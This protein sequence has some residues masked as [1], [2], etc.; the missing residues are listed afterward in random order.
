VNDFAVAT[1]KPFTRYFAQEDLTQLAHRQFYTGYGGGY[2]LFPNADAEKTVSVDY[3]WV[4]GVTG[5]LHTELG[6]LHRLQPP[7]T[8]FAPTAGCTGAGAF[9]PGGR[10]W[11]RLTH[12]DA[13]V[14]KGGSTDANA[15]T[16][17]QPGSILIRG[18]RG[19]SLH[20]HVVWREAN[21]WR[22]RERSTILTREQS[23]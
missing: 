3:T 16:E 12:S 11:V 19:A 8:A 13:D 21:R 1:L 10:W 14:C 4:N 23:R 15:D 17:V 7:A 22:H 9:D 18:V 2:L 6:E 5:A 20:T